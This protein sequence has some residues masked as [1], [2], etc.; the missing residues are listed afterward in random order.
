MPHELELLQ[1]QITRLE[2]Q[3]RWLTIAAV[4]LAVLAI[5]AWLQ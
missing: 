4:V 5:R 2:H 1:H 3:L